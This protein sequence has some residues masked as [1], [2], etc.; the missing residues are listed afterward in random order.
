MVVMLAVMVMARRERR[1]RHH[2]H[3]DEKQR[4]KLFHGRILS[5][6]LNGIQAL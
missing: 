2:D 4:Q 5:M 3:H 1:H 6:V